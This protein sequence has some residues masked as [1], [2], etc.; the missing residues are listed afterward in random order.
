MKIL[1]CNNVS[2]NFGGVAAV[3]DVDLEVEQGGIVGLVGPNGSGKTTLFNV[4]TGIYPVTG[5]TITYAG[6]PIHNRSTHRIIEA[7]IARTFQNIRLFSRMSVL[8]NVLVGYHRCLHVGLVPILLRSNL[9]SEAEVEA[10]DKSLEWLEFVGLLDEQSMWAGDLSYGQQRR[11]EIARAL[12]S[13]PALLLLDEPS[14]GMNPK[15]VDDLIDLFGDLN[16]ELGKTLF[17][18]E[19]NMD[20]IMTISDIIYCLDA[21]QR[22][23][24]GTPSQVQQDELVRAAYLGE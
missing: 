7:G 17:I 11:L 19:H 13:D 24:C 18:I 8:E 23:A 16:K 12:A 15:E 4:I 14:A 3:C 9:A 10:V 6:Q 2:K 20:V 1:V 21:G 22:I 5:G